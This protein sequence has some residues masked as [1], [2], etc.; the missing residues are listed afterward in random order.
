MLV[1]LAAVLGIVFRGSHVMT[2]FGISFVPLLFVLLMI[3][4]GKQMSHNAGTHV[5]GLMMIW[6]GLLVVAGLD[7]WTLTR[8]LRR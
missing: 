2:A 3:V 6:S 7:V 4:T 8:V 1:I 5:L